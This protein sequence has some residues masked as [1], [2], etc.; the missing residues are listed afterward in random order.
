MSNALQEQN[1]W[2]NEEIFDRLWVKNKKAPNLFQGLQYLLLHLF[3]QEKRLL[4]RTLS[5]WVDHCQVKSWIAKL[6]KIP[7]WPGQ[8]Q[9]T[10]H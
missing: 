2:I 3:I 1:D 4:K 7:G 10:S 6:R 8:R 5:D 9:E